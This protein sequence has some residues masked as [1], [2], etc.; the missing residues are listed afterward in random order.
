M[1]ENINEKL[2]A[3]LSSPDLMSNVQKVLSGFSGEKT[4][5]N[6][7]V[8]KNEILP[9]VSDVIQVL[10]SNNIISGLGSFFREN[11]SERIALLS[12]LRPFLSKEKQETLDFIVQLLKIAGIL[13]ATNV[14]S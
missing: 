8:V 9:D 7:S 10:S 1:D 6:S 11:Q 2:S 4:I 5:S 13:F 14:A 3:L 12:A